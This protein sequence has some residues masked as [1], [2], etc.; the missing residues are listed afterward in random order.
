[1]CITQEKFM[2]RMSLTGCLFVRCSNDMNF[3]RVIESHLP[4]S[5]GS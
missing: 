3:N 1:M 2:N 4:G 5:E